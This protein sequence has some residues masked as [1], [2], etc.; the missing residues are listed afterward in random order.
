MNYQIIIDK[1]YPEDNALREI[2]LIHSRQVAD[3]CLKIAKHH[4]EL[5]LEVEFL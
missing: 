2:L 5:K 3:R 1:Y 4:P